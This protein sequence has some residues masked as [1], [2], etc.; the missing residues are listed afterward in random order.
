MDWYYE[1]NGKQQGPVPESKLAELVDSGVVGASTRVWNN[2]LSEWTQLDT[3]A[4]HLLNRSVPE[5]ST[6]PAQSDNPYQP[7]A[8][9]GTGPA[10]PGAA[11]S[12]QTIPGF[13]KGW[14]I[15]DI[16][17]CSF[18][19]LAICGIATSESAWDVMNLLLSLVIGGVGLTAAIMILNQK[20]GGIPLAWTTVAA[21]IVHIIFGFA[22]ISVV[23]FASLPEFQEIPL[24]ERDLFSGIVVGAVI[25]TGII[26]AILLIFYIKAVK[27]ASVWFGSK[28]GAGVV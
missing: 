23:D 5:T 20:P 13:V 8:Q 12:G 24:S 21:V 27:R 3:A 16:V 6:T 14:M 10:G 17:F 9:L 4:P 19:L 7:P 18:N 15:A 1:Q 2:G 11:A 28:S 22:M 25:V 26:R